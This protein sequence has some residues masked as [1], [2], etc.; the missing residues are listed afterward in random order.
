[1]AA[2]AGRAAHAADG[3]GVRRCQPAPGGRLRLVDA[4]LARTARWRARAPRRGCVRAIRP[5]A[6]RASGVGMLTARQI[7]RVVIAAL[8][9]D[10]PWGDV[11]SATIRSRRC[12]RDGRPGRTRGRRVQRRRRSR[13]RS[14]SP[15][16]PPPSPW[17]LPMARA[18]GA[19]DV[20]ATV[21]GS[22]TRRPDGRTG[23]SQPRAAH[24]RHAHPHR[25]LRRRGR[26]TGA[27]IADTRKTTPGC[28]RSN[29]TLSAAAAVTTTATRC[30]TP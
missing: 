13:R 14:P 8:E 26:R 6:T 23:G 22:G 21:S 3:G 1:M 16:P 4:A 11:T 5:G 24:E 30:R 17:R 15:T 28:G 7:E 20:L 10:A 2:L 12:R 25:A 19:G 27:R 9:E 18:F 29:A